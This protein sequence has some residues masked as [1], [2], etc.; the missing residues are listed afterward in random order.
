MQNLSV[1]LATFNEEKNLPDCLSSIKELADEIIIV[2]G[3]SADKTVEIAKKYGAKVTVTDNPPIFHINKQKAL[4]LATKDWI[5]QLDADERVSAD[6]AREIKHIISLSNQEIENY[7][8]SLPNRNLFLRHQKL[9]EDRD[10]RIGTESNE[11]TAFFIPRYNY[12]LGKYL[13]YGGVYPDGVIRLMKRGK[14]HFPCK[15]VHE[16]IAV[17]GK[18]GWLGHPLY[19]YDSPTFKRYLTRLT[20]YTILIA[21]ELKEKRTGRNPLVMVKYMILLPIGWFVLTYVRHKG[22]IDGWQGFV[23]SFFSSM[24]FPIAYMKYLKNN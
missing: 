10:G 22:F 1:V 21:K 19:H 20:R 17:E 8:E 16:Q 23:F 13:Q 9:L 15:D 6:L 18:V 11:Y 2:D 12:F 5:L 7:Q 4:E 24:R 14:A 3:S